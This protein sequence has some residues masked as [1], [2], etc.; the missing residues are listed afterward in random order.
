MLFENE[1][2][3]DSLSLAKGTLMEY[4]CRDARDYK[5]TKTLL[6]ESFQAKISTKTSRIRSHSVEQVYLTVQLTVNK[7]NLPSAR[8][9][10]LSAFL[11]TVVSLGP[12]F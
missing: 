2:E 3:E 11:T 7:Q 12:K 4:V 9:H 8:T 5:T 6:L 1:R 10:K